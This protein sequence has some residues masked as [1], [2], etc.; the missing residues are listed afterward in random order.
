MNQKIRAVIMCGGSGTRLAPLTTETPKQF[1]PLSDPH[2]SMIQLT[3]KRIQPLITDALTV[4]TNAKQAHWVKEQLP[5]AQIILEPEPRNTAPALGLTALYM[6][7]NDVMLVFPADHI[8]A[9]EDILRERL[10]YA[11]T[12]AASND[13]LV[14]L[15]MLPTHPHTGLGHIERSVAIDN[16][17]ASYRVARFVEKPPYEKAK[18]YTESGRYYWNGGMF[19]WRVGFFLERMALCAKD[20]YAG[21]MQ[22]KESKLSPDVIAEIFPRLPKISV[23]YAI[24]EKSAECTAVIECKDLGWNDL[25]DWSVLGA[26]WDRD[27]NGN[28]IR[29]SVTVSDCS[30]CVMCNQGL[31]NLSV[32]GLHDAVIVKAQNRLLI[33]PRK[34]TQL[35][36]KTAETFASCTDTVI[37]LGVPNISITQ[38]DKQWIIAAN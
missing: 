34:S 29:G 35:V 2:A 30:N 11:A 27:S 15:G 7:P 20:L 31:G 21:L 18:E 22:I 28:A 13:L 17:R 10:G 1:L 4:V 6:D 5:Q 12:L 9:N 25:G 33:S 14:T 37:N 36:G 19:A 38:K 24:L 23:D 8:F 32:S 16:S 26:I 3:A